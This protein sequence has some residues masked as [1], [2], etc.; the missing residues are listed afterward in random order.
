MSW[1]QL[2]HV[3]ASAFAV[4]ASVCVSALSLAACGGDDAPARSVRLDAAADGSL[5]FERRAVTTQAGRVTIE[6]AN[7][8]DIPHAI[9]IRGGGVDETGKTVGKGGTSSVEAQVERGRYTLFC[10]VAGHEEAG[11]V[12]VLT[13]E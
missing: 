3:R 2:K 13:V 10:P 1:A 6:M 11:M 9:G 5:R 7:P 8:A 12:A 4:G